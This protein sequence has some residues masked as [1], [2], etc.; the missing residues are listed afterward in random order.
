VEDQVAPSGWAAGDII[1]ALTR[2]VADLEGRLLSMQAELDATMRRI[3]VHAESDRSLNDARAERYRSADEIARRA[4][5]EADQILERAADQRRMLTGDV[6][7]LREEK[8]A[9][10]EEIT[11]LHGDD[12]S[13]VRQPLDPGSSP[14][15]DLQTA[16][17]E[18]MRSL[19]LEIVSEVGARS[20]V[21]P[22]I[23]EQ[24]VA[25]SDVAVAIAGAPTVEPV[26]ELMKAP[27][28]GPIEDE[29]VE[30]LRA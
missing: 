14:A 12:L 2:R 18:E 25:K 28:A 17:M 26:D 10:R 5:A 15:F 20:A 19:L 6:Q 23:I 13:A 3:A 11:S 1:P 16:V 30:E 4:R 22:A 27:S 8:D 24:V 21:V 7:R 29:Y 9:L